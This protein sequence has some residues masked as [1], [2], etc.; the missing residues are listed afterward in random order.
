M[1]FSA[2]TAIGLIFY[3]A[4]EPLAHYTGSNRYAQAGYLSDNEAAQNAINVTLYHWGL[5]G[6]VVYTLTG[7]LL[8]VL[9]WKHDLP[10]TY[11]SCF[12]PLFGRATWGWMGDIVDSITIVGVV[13]GVCTSLGLGAAQTVTGMQ[14]IGW[15]SDDLDSQAVTQYRCVVIGVITLM[16]T[17]SVVTGLSNGVK[18]LSQIAFGMGMFLMCMVFF[19][20]NPWYL[21]NLMTQSAGFY[22]QWLTQIGW[23]CDAF[24]QLNWGEGRAMDG[25]G[26]HESWMN[27]WTI[28]YWGWWISWSPFVGVFLARISRGRTVRNVINFTISVPMI[29][30]TMWFCVFGGSGLRMT[31]RAALLEKAGTELYGNASYFVD[32]SIKAG[33]CYKV[34]VQLPCPAQGV[35]ITNATNCP[36]YTNKKYVSTPELSPVCAFRSS[37]SD[38]FWFDLMNQYYGLGPLLWGF[39]ILTIVLFFVTSSD[40][41][42]MVVDL[43]ANNGREAHVIQRI[44][45]SFT[46]GGLA[47]S[48]LIAGGEL[49][50]KALRSAA[51]IAGVP[52]TV[53]V[54]YISLAL[55]RTLAYGEG[56]SVVRYWAMPLYGG[57]F[58][59]GEWV[60]SLGGSPLP[61]LEHTRGFLLALV[62][63]PVVLYRALIT[64]PVKEGRQK[65]AIVM[66]SATTF[67]FVGFVLCHVLAPTVVGLGGLM[68]LAWFC[69]CCFALAVMAV[70]YE[71]RSLYS[72]EGSPVEDA[73]VALFFYP[74][75]IWQMAVQVREP[76]P[77]EEPRK[78][79]VLENLEVEAQA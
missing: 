40:S 41:G 79:E 53:F 37:D 21:L 74:Q 12:W 14:R 59:V 28:F 1:L 25:K 70:R 71:L 6:W 45:W 78:V 69:Y 9:S 26:G 44:F 35:I 10:M 18:M 63:P 16:A 54:C 52:F 60:F 65:R 64:W 19:L 68:G 55:W 66:V 2:G 76:V 13:A 5:H 32:P 56:K 4:S 67:S 8:G 34:P 61:N 20:D 43:I 15:L 36:S 48:L 42:S 72:I 58:D 31:R 47:M 7:L 49:A 73:L 29:Y 39:T 11:R 57:I 75:V 77:M 22:V 24:A 3:G 46:E 17:C 50:L 27:W 33:N 23:Y 38:G 30:C 51:I 62:C